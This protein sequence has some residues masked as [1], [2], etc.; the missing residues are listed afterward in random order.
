MTGTYLTRKVWSDAAAMLVAIIVAMGSQALFSYLMA[1]LFGP[2]N[3][4]V[5]TLALTVLYM[6]T[7]LIVLGSDAFG[8]RRIATDH[9]SAP[10]IPSILLTFQIL[11]ATAI[12]MGIATLLM[13]CPMSDLERAFIGI[14]TPGLL[15]DVITAVVGTSLCGRG[16]FGQFATFTA[17]S[18]VAVLVIAGTAGLQGASLMQ[19][20]GIL[21]ML[22][23][24]TA[25]AAWGLHR[26]AVGPLW[27]AGPVQAYR[28]LLRPSFPYFLATLLAALHM[29]VSIPLIRIML[30]TDELGLYGLAATVANAAAV[31]CIQPL[32]LSL[33]PAVAREG[34]SNSIL[35]SRRALRTLGIP[36]AVGLVGGGTLCLVAG[37]LIDITL[38]PMYARSVPLLQ[39]LAWFL[40]PI[41]VSSTA[42][43]M[44]MACGHTRAAVRILAVNVAVNVAANLVLIPRVGIRGAAWAMV[45]SALVSALQT[46][47]FLDKGVPH[48]NLDK[49]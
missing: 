14:M 37:P 31:V 34:G 27:P 24:I 29:K 28:S 20:G 8:M 21:L 38:G 39:I 6:A 40:P 10:L 33:F 7:P 1:R 44:M 36:L 43:R 11:N 46:V 18:S 12:V 2:R 5:L 19:V 47:I 32:S 41:F 30:G 17:V 22:K 35:H 23:L 26:Y 49:P 16:R 3:Y 25:L 15:P 9:F 48:S 45:L 13:V 4:G 42:I